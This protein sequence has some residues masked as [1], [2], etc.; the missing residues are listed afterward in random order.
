MDFDEIVCGSKTRENY[1]FLLKTD[2]RFEG[3][4]PPSSG[5]WKVSEGKRGDRGEGHVVFTS[6]RRSKE[7]AS[8]TSVKNKKIDVIFSL[9]WTLDCLI[10]IHLIH[11]PVRFQKLLNYIKL[12]CQIHCQSIISIFGLFVFRIG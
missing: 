5:F 11:L 4:F 12:K 10:K 6:P 3:F 2:R 1:I 9:F 7:E 8:E